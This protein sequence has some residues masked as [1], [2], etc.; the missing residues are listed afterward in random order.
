MNSKYSLVFFSVGVV[1]ILG[2]VLFGIVPMNIISEFE[3][4]DNKEQLT[5]EEIMV[6][7]IES[8]PIEQMNCAELT[9]FILSFEKGWGA[10]VTLYNEKCS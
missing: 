9:E 10:A 2:F 6:I 4:G 3:S 5:V 7:P 8:K 1:L